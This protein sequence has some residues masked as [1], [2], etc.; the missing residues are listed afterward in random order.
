MG[1]GRGDLAALLRDH[2][3]ELGRNC[4]FV[5]DGRR[6]LQEGARLTIEEARVGLYPIV[7]LEKQRPNVIG[8]LV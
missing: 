2:A 1:W 8:N 3:F 6:G 4:K 5:L 7:T